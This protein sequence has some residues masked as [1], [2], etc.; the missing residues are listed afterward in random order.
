MHMSGGECAR[1]MRGGDKGV[2]SIKKKI[3]EPP[4]LQTLYNKFSKGG[5]KKLNGHHASCYIGARQV[6]Y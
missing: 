3:K 1:I 5:N 2:Q 4:A 6:G